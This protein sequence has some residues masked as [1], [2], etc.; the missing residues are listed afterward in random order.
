APVIADIR[1]ILTSADPEVAIQQAKTVEQI[2]DDS[3]A[4]RRF[5]TNLAIAFALAGLV[6]ASLGIYGVISFAVARRTA[7][8]GLR[9]ALGAG[10]TRVVAMVMRGGMLPVLAGIAVGVAC[11]LSTSRLLASQLF[12]VSPNDPA[13]M[14]TVVGVLLAVAICACWVPARRAARIDPMRALRF[15]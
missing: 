11:A 14:L 10:R 6:L 7:E 3:V 13:I 12:G 9:I 15:E 4:P 1:T 5:Q 8:I 2:L